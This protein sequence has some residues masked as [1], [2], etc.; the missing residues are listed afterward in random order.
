MQASGNEQLTPAFHTGVEKQRQKMH[1]NQNIKEIR[2]SLSDN[3]IFM[4]GLN[5]GESPSNIETKQESR[6]TRQ[7]RNTSLK[8]AHSKAFQQGAAKGS[9]KRKE[10]TMKKVTK[11][12]ESAQTLEDLKADL[13]ALNDIKARKQKNG[14]LRRLQDDLIKSNLL[15]VSENPKRKGAKRDRFIVDFMQ[16]AWIEREREMDLAAL[17]AN[18][19]KLTGAQTFDF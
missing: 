12:L 5:K 18:H 13:S 11:S 3:K 15:K 16:Q 1:G 10:K 19:Y 8:Q 14:T 17:A 7:A 2:R 4:Q 9:L 6:W